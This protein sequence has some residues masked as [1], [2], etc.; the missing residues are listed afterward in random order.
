MKALI[1][2]VLLFAAVVFAVYHFGGYGKLDPSQQGR[3]ARAA[4]TAGM[5]WTQVVTAAGAPRHFVLL[6]EAGKHPTTG[7]P[8]IK[9]GPKMN[10]NAD[11]IAARV[12]DG[13]AP[14]GFFFPYT[15]SHSEAFKVEFDAAGTVVYVDD[16]QTLNKLLDM[17]KK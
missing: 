12:K 14:H 8:L 13:T 15:F 7:E 3:N 17:P 16:L 4:I 6:I 10:Y 2:L 5:T 11:A 1:I 9:D